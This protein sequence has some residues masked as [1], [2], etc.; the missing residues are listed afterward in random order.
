VRIDGVDPCSL[1]TPEQRTELGLDG[2]PVFDLGPS[3]L[4]RDARVPACVVGGF[5]PRA[6]TVGV[7]LVTSAGVELFTSGKLEVDMRPVQVRDF[8]A[9]VAV[10][11]RFT[12]WCTVIVDVAPSQLLDIQFADG[13]RMPPIPQTQLCHDAE[14]VAD[15]VMA[16]LLASR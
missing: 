13:G 6:I 3:E 15:S 11:R 4:Y 1:L 10:P 5:S 16:T 7:S 14:T 9:V 2:R 8:P 12:E